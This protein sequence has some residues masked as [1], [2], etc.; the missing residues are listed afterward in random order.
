MLA[1]PR[2]FRATVAWIAVVVSA[3]GLCCFGTVEIDVRPGEQEAAP[4]QF[5]TPVFALRTTEA[6]A[7]AVSIVI[8]APAGWQILD[9]EDLVAIPPDDEA[10]V[11]VT[12]IVPAGAAAGAYELTLT[13]VS[14]VDPD[15]R[16]SGFARILVSPI[17]RIELLEPVGTSVAPGGAVEY[18]LTLTN[19]GNAQDTV[20]IDAFSSRGL[21]LALS[22]DT[23][24]LA[25]QERATIVARLEVPVSTDPG[26][27]VLTVTATSILYEG[28]EDQAVVF[29][30][31]LPPTP[32]VVGGTLIEI[33]PARLRLSIGQDVLDG[34]FDSRMTFST[35]GRVL[36]G[37]FSSF[38]SVDTPLGPDPL[39]VTSYS[40][41]YRRQPTITTLGN[42]SKRLT[43]LVSLTCEGGSFEID[44]EVLD[45]T[46]VAGLYDDE[47]R[48]GGYFAMG[49][50]VANV[51][52]SFFDARNPTE[53]RAIGGATAEAEPLEDWRIF[54][55]AALGT[56]A[57]RTSRAFL[58][59]TEIDTA[60]YFL[61][62]EVFSIGTGFPGSESDSAGI[63]L[64]QRLRMTD[65]S[66]SLSLSHEWDNVVRDPLESTQVDDE[67][68]FNLS[69]TPIEDGPRLS[70]TVEFAWSRLDDPTLASDIDLLLSLGVRETDGVFPY[71]FSGEIEDRIDLAFGTHTRTLTFTEG[72][73]LSVDSFYLFLQLTQEKSIDVLT[74]NVLAGETDVS[75]LFRPEGTLHEASI[76]L[77]NTED[78]FDLTASID[79]RFND[80]LD[81]MFDGSIGW[82]RG[83]AEPTSFGWGISFSA[84][85]QIPLPFLLTKGRIEGRLFVDLD[86]DGAFDDED[87]PIGAGI[88]AVDG[89][90]VST[91]ET[92]FFRFPPLSI[93]DYT[94]TVRN[95]PA[96]ALPAG[97]LDVR[98]V[99]GETTIVSVPLR[100]ILVIEGIVFEDADQD[101]TQGPGEGGFADI[102]VLLTDA[103]GDTL[104][105]GSDSFG[106]FA[107]ANVDPGSYI[108]SVDPA[109]LP[110]RFTFTTEEA[111][112]IDLAGPSGAQVAFGG[113]IRP[114]EVVVTFQPPTADFTLTPEEP[115]AGE[116]VTFDGSLSFDFDGKIVAYAW[117]FDGD[118][119]V[120]ATDPIVEWSFETAGEASVSLTVTD[121]TGNEDTLV[122][123]IPISEGEA[124]EEPV[125]SSFQPPIADF[126]FAPESPRVGDA[127][128]F[129]GTLSFDFDGE[130]VLYSWDFGDDGTSDA[131]GPTAI[132]TFSTAAAVAV[133]LT[134]TDDGG[135]S[136]SIVRTVDVSAVP[137]EEP[138]DV[139]PSL[140]PPT[141]DFSYAPGRPIAGEPV[142]FD[143]SPSSDPDGEIVGFAWISTGTGR[144]TRPSRSSSTR[145]RPRGTSVS[146]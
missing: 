131:A 21:P 49:P 99:S 103:D 51:G 133:R 129:D 55:E 92:G 59:G 122:Q 44:D 18:E 42:V 127:V 9:V 140:L 136:D 68:G 105:A 38:L 83:D 146:V 88:L 135:N 27:D 125:S 41:L 35:S 128:A 12:V 118:S 67:L 3:F 104:I 25:P 144:S 96:D 10:A 39:Q 138:V 141:A 108:V 11:F 72:A 15:D 111:A 112:A 23:F 107:F 7:V 19:R 89:T 16:T 79:I 81:I 73:G 2:G 114:R 34:T 123:A 95:V 17:N 90:E 6:D 78:E 50:E 145:S 14:E 132:R 32:D 84:D 13:A 64:S 53:R 66:I 54:A 121:E 24:D 74:D 63:R 94:L 5:V 28:V 126:S 33:L 47:A 46:L 75:I 52:F 130:I 56:D 86:G 120:D 8:D 22:G 87:R 30:T 142:T 97:P 20:I 71:A 143:A 119:A 43:D 137:A 100:P 134:V 85:L 62:G 115:V 40:L 82:D 76:R 1:R 58:F 116:P 80:W 48:F 69:A 45:V 65:L 124:V 139:R 91:D 4:G 106:R 110:A 98:V 102:R 113:Y 26:Q 109:S 117:D 36:D 61:N 31:I 93:G 70:S 77:G 101:G 60:G 29:T 37:F 57:G